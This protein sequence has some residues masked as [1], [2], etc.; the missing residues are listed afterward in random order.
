MSKVYVVQEMPNHDIASA[1]K[2]GEL[3][4]LLPS[5]TQIAFSTSPDPPTKAQA[6]GL[7]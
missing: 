1:M 5:N 6:T 2:F 3:S 4:V 7:H